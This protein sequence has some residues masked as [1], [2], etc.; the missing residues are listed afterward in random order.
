M[1]ASSECGIAHCDDFESECRFGRPPM[2]FVFDVQHVSIATCETMLL[3]NK[4]EMNKYRYASYDWFLYSSNE[5]DVLP[6]PADH[7]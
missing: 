7:A 5:L 6:I 2:L 3:L 4:I 1:Q